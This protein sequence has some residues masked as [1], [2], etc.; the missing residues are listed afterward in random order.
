MPEF[1]DLLFLL[2][3]YFAPHLDPEKKRQFRIAFNT[4]LEWNQRINVVS[5]KD[6]ENLAEAMQEQG[7]I[8]FRIDRSV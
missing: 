6:I 8:A 7:R 5:R 1:A 4:Y 2:E 3:K